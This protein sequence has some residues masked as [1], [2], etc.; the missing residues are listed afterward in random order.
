MGWDTRTGVEAVRMAVWPSESNWGVWPPLEVPVEAPP[1]Y[2]SWTL[3]P[4]RPVTVHDVDFDC[5][6]VVHP[7]G[8]FPPASLSGPLWALRVVLVS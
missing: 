3:N 1:W 6:P 8:A 4:S 7:E 2:L 5:F